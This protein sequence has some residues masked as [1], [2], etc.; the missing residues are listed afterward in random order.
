MR[1]VSAMNP[2]L[3]QDA[4]QS[5]RPSPT[6]RPL[7]TQLKL[8]V[9]ASYTINP[10]IPHLGTALAEG[11]FEL[12]P[13]VGPYNQIVQECLDDKSG[14]AAFRPG[15][16][17]VS[18]RLEELWG[19][20]AP[21]GPVARG[22][23]R[24]GPGDLTDVVD[25]A[26]AAARRWQATLLLVLP[27]VP[28]GALGAP[29]DDSD[30]AGHAATAYA[31]REQARRQIAERPGAYTVD[32]EAVVR[33]V[34][35]AR[36]YHP[37]LFQYAKIPFT[38]EVFAELGTRLGRLLRLRFGEAC[39]A[40]VLDLLGLVREEAD[41]ERLIPVVRRLKAYG[42]PV[43][44]R[45]DA[46]AAGLWRRLGAAGSELAALADDWVF[47]DNGVGSHVRVLAGH[48][49][50]VALISQDAGTL[51]AAS[52]WPSTVKPLELGTDPDC[53]WS[54]LCARS[55][56]GCLTVPAVG[57]QPAAAETGQRARAALSLGA[58]LESLGVEVEVSPARETQLEKVDEVMLRAKDF[59]LGS[60]LDRQQVTAAL[61]D[62]DRRVLVGVVRDRFGD[63]GL[64][65]VAVLHLDDPVCVVEALL[66][67]CPVMGRGVEEVVMR[68]IALEAAEYGCGRV[69]IRCTDTGR[70]RVALDFARAAAGRDWLP[71]GA[72]SPAVEM[73]VVR[74]AASEGA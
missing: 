47:D 43:Y 37:G 14:T 2:A 41:G 54:E 73:A 68:R 36:A 49:L 30:P 3:S 56:F 66:L 16:L 45:G 8:A 4:G 55:V 46:A 17:V 42:L 53:W 21:R 62:P 48:R 22:S 24:P 59:T 50:P 20:Q 44:V 65:V 72:N 18:P 74:P 63:Y 57:A 31:A 27:P 70:N 64:S 33:T 39:R 52:A 12:V 38:G 32:L 5:A 51:S 11:G 26:L 61:A 10:L 1:G 25:V 69:L 29:G 9:L 71:D 23:R 35:A 40:A 19:E 28:E 7:A 34:G 60:V 58:F 15:V 67:S 6:S 13:H